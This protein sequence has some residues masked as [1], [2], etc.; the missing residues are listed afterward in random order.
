[1]IAFAVKRGCGQEAEMDPC[2]RPVFVFFG[3]KGC[4]LQSWYVTTP[5]SS[6]DHQDYVFFVADPYEPPRMLTQ[7]CGHNVTSTVCLG[8]LMSIAVLHCS[9]ASMFKPASDWVKSQ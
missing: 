8:K 2:Q 7:N 1:M 6:S 4:I 5:P 9:F 3:K